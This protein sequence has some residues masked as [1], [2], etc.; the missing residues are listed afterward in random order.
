M[1]Q[2][3]AQHPNR[4]RPLLRNA[5]LTIREVHRET[6]IPESTLYYWAAGHGIIPKEDRI[7]LANII[8]CFPYD[9]APQYDMLELQLENASSR[10]GREML[11]RRRELLQLL[12]IAGGALFA[13]DVGWNHIESSLTKLSH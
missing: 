5:G 10:W 11:I 9:L 4:L 2:K 13:S 7:T 6:N 3:R 12:N 8:G 1:M